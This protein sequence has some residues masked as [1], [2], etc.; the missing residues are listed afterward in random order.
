MGCRTASSDLSGQT[1]QSTFNFQ[2]HV[3]SPPRPQVSIAFISAFYLCG[4]VPSFFGFALVLFLWFLELNFRAIY[5][6]NLSVV[7]L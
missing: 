1:F 7:A 2:N 4:F 5:F 6:P 3:Y